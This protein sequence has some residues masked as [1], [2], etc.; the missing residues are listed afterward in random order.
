M[1]TLLP[2]A[3]IT[4][5][6]TNPAEDLL[7]VSYFYLQALSHSHLQMYMCTQHTQISTLNITIGRFSPLATDVGS[8]SGPPLEHAPEPD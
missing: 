2:K 4:P 6:S 8:H 3:A 7:T 5:Q 1:T